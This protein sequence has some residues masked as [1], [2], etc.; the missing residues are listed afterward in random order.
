MEGHPTFE[1]LVDWLE[2]RLDPATHQAVDAHIATGCPICAKDVNWLRRFRA[3]ARND[4]LATPSPALV[5]RVKSLYSPERFRRAAP[6]RPWWAIFAQ[7]PALAIGALLVI[8][9]L[10]VTL[11]LG[12]LPALLG[13][14]AW[15]AALQ[16]TIEMQPAERSDW[17]TISPG[18]ALRDGD[19]VRAVEGAALLL[20]F[21]GSRVELHAGTELMLSSMRSGLFGKPYRI[22]LQQ[23]SGYAYYTVAPLQSPRSSFEVQSPTALVAVRGTSFAIA[24]ENASE[25]RVVVLAGRVQ[26]ESAE[27]KVVLS[28]REAALISSAGSFTALPTLTPTATPPVGAARR[29]YPATGW[30]PTFSPTAVRVTHTPTQTPTATITP[31]EGQTGPNPE[32]PPDQV[33]ATA[34][35]VATT[36]SAI[37]GDDWPPRLRTP[38]WWLTETPDMRENPWPWL[39]TRTPT[40]SGTPYDE[41]RTQTVWP[42]ITRTPEPT[43][44]R[45][46]PRPTRTPRP[47]H[48]PEPTH[49]PVRPWPTRWP[50][51]TD[52]PQPSPQPPPWWPTDWPRPPGWPWPNIPPR[53][54]E[55]P[56]PP[57]HKEPPATPVPP[58]RPTP[59]PDSKHDTDDIRVSAAMPTRALAPPQAL[60]PPPHE[61]APDVSFAQQIPLQGKI[62]AQHSLN[63]KGA[64]L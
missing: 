3:A 31:S 28:E 38:G 11:Y 33:M 55:T 20:L 46:P 63:E 17:Q 62:S 9:A 12:R 45:E 54:P 40:P 56:E 2:G 21:D 6:V 42:R 18:Q 19:K 15:L 61:N 1:N 43:D 59:R 57:P 8:L 36:V 51:P 34:A 16:G 49:T 22:A 44:T 29:P 47:T 35:A 30:T 50:W 27:T 41:R 23:S 52:G 10:S 14:D 58:P 24:V 13:R 60:S 7:R 32:S 53:V 4:T 26:V 5:A 37:H 64:R 25:T 48:M 39:W